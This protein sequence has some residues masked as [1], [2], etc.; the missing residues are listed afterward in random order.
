MVQRLRILRI[1]NPEALTDGKTYLKA[2]V[3][4]VEDDDDEELPELE[5]QFLGCVCVFFFF[6]FSSLFFES[7]H[8]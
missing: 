4:E 3:E 8:V 5:A 1:L 7:R 6:F 2:E